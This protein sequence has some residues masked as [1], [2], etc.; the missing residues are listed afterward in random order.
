MRGRDL[1]LFRP[2]RDLLL[3]RPLVG[4]DL[5]LRLGEA[6]GHVIERVGQ[7]TDL[8]GGPR[9]NVDVQLAGPDRPRRRIR[10]RIG[11]TSP[12]VRNSVAPMRG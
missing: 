10:R 7:Q 3:Q 11:A 6:L 12:R 1:Q 5:V 8:V 4:R 9:R 2:L